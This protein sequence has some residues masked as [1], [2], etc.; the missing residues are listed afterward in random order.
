M[1]SNA[2]IYV[3]G[4]IIAAFAIVGGCWV[5]HQIFGG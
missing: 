2:I 3:I 1:I 5:L 4:S